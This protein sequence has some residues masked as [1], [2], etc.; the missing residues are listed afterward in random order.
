MKRHMSFGRAKIGVKLHRAKVLRNGERRL[1]RK[2]H[3]FVLRIRPSLK[4]IMLFHNGR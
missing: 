4:F 3:K 2:W 1:Y